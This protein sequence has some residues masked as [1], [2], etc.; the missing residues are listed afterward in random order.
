DATAPETCRRQEKYKSPEGAAPY[1]KPYVQAGS[2]FFVAKV[3]P[4]KVKI[5][6]GHAALS[7][8]RFH[9]D[10]SDFTLPVRLGLINS[11]G[12]QDLIVNVLA[13]NRRYEP[14][15]YPSVTIPTNIDVA[16][17]SRTSFGKF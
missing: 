7:P 13:Q 12:T 17:D 9:Y 16:E 14:A 8:L 3:D 4:K 11:G 1:L 6:N 2:K 15:N 5:E 10:S